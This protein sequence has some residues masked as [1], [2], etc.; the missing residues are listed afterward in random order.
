MPPKP[1]HSLRTRIS[2]KRDKLIDSLFERAEYVDF[3]TLRWGDLLRS[4]RK[5]LSER[6]LAAFNGWIR[7]SV[8]E[9]KPWNQMARELIVASGSTYE[10]PANFFRTASTPETQAETTSQV[11]LG[12]RI[13]CARCHNHPYEKWKQ[14]QYYQMAAFFAR[15]RTKKGKTPDENYVIVG[16]SG[17]ERH[18]KTNKSVAPC[19]LDARPVPAAYNGDRREALADWITSPQNPFFAKI[20]VNRVWKHFMGRGL[21]EPVDDLRVTNPG[22]QR[23]A[24]RLARGRLRQTRL[25]P[26]P[27]NEDDDADRSLPARCR[28]GRRQRAGFEFYSHYLFKRLT[29]EQL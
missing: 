26:P 23:S 24:V 3:W 14:N 20:I 6:A 17:E 28:A 4:S 9:N 12:V 7:R 19:A 13:Q 25:R 16:N 8:Q 5:Y 11:F 22:L 29:A 27:A 2:N 1:T 21:V 15:V 18:P 10:G